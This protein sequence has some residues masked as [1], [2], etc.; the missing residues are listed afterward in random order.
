MRI[1][2]DCKYCIVFIITLIAVVL[3]IIIII[4]KDAHFFQP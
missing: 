1:L 4:V 2:I 3:H